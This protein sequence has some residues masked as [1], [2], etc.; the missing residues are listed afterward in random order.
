MYIIVTE[1]SSWDN[2]IIANTA[3][4]LSPVWKTCKQKTVPDIQTD[5][6]K[7]NIVCTRG[8]KKKEYSC[9]YCNATA[10]SIPAL[11]VK[12]CSKHPKGFLSGQHEPIED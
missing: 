5:S 3:D 9:K 7:V 2:D 10:E 1:G 11:T 4:N 6:M 12:L 8:L